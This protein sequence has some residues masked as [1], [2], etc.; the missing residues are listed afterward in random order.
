MGKKEKPDRSERPFLKE[1]FAG[2]PATF[3]AEMK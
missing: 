3:F 2:K 1:M